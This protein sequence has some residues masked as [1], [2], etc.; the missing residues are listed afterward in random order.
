[1]ETTMNQQL[2]LPE[3]VAAYFTEKRDATMLARWF[4]SDAVVR[5]EGHTHNGLAA[6][7]EWQADVS[8][9]YSFTCEPLTLE[10]KDGITV[11]SSRVTG[12]FPGSPVELR[13]R[14]RLE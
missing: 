13:Y 3:P 10:H 4:T 11:V 2:D 5:D 7:S 14:F 1:M 12:N 9:K 6:I 8:A